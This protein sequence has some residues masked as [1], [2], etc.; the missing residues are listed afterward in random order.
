MTFSAKM[1]LGN[2]YA[3]NL[4]YSHKHSLIPRLHAKFSF[5]KLCKTITNWQ[6]DNEVNKSPTVS[7]KYDQKESSGMYSTSFMKESIA[8]QKKIAL[9]NVLKVQPYDRL[10]NT[11]FEPR[12]IVMEKN[13]GADIKTFNWEGIH[14]EI[15]PTKSESQN[16]PL[17]NDYSQEMN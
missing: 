11:S 17:Q 9:N 14:F 13:E 15:T 16:V 7:K 6:I 10:K 3:K 12:R 2:T 5:S 1:L 4:N 8:V